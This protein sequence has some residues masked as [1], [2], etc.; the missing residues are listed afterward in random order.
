MFEADTAVILIIM[1]K[2]DLIFF[3]FEMSDIFVLVL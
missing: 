2:A 3:N 1:Q